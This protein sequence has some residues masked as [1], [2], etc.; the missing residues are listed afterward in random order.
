MKEKIIFILTLAASIIFIAAVIFVFP[1]TEEKI[2]GIK[3]ENGVQIIQIF[4][5]NGFTPKK[6]TAKAEMPTRL[7]VETKGTYD[8]SSALV[9]PT[10]SY[11]KNLPQTGIT[12]I[13]IPTQEKGSNITGLCAMGMY[14]FSI[15]FV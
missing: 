15:D 10:L 2:S 13:E 4:A 9:I 3:E 5:R 12:K 8:C 7:E 14:S 11:K 6:I 1:K